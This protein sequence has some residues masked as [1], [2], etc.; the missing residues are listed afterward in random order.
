MSLAL[1]RPE[2]LYKKVIIGGRSLEMED[3]LMVACNAV[4]VEFSKDPEWH[5]KIRAGAEFVDQALKEHREIYGVTTGYGQSG[6]RVVPQELMLDLSKYLVRF[7]GCGMGEILPEPLAKA[8]M[9]VRLNSLAYGHSGVRMDLLDLMRELINLSII[10]VIPEEGSVGASGDLTPLSYVAAVLMGERDVFYQGRH[11]QTSEVFKELDI[12][13]LTLMPKESLAVMNGTSVMTAIA[14]FAF[15]RAEY[16]SRL[17]SRI[18]A[19]VVEVLR[20]NKSH[21]DARIFAY[22]PHPGQSLIATYI[23]EDLGYHSRDSKALNHHLQDRYS[24][25]CAPHVIGVLADALPWM[26]EWIE[27]ELNS[28]NDN[29]LVDAE[30]EDF[31]HGGNFYGGHIAFAMDGLKNAVANVADLLDRQMAFMMDPK[32]NRGLPANLSGATEERLCISHGFK[33]M[34]IGTAAWTAEALKN[35]MPASVFSRSTECHNQDKVS[36]GTIAARDCLRVLELTEQVAGA[37]LLAATQGLEI[38][39]RNGELEPNHLTPQIRETLD[40]IRGE[41]DFIEDDR[42]LE[43]TLRR[44]KSLIAEKAWALYED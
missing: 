5:R 24:L 7:H 1:K 4:P 37:V 33:A 44:I 35:T 30:Q 11:R 9:V 31:L 2:S 27:T 19:M 15:Q 29:P 34:E 26:K 40:A 10:P 12:Q 14:C 36:M 20:G 42:P 32:N 23:R 6:I 39:I 16:L 13:P 22:K 25:R 17:A 3:V 43:Q 21:Y 38:R 18:T 8:V 28:A 41:C